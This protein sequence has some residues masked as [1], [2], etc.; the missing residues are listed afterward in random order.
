MEPAAA[1]LRR[2]SAL[3]PDE[4]EPTFLLALAAHHVGRNPERGYRRTLALAADHI[5]AEINLA[6]WLAAEGRLAASSMRLRRA[7]VLAP[8]VPQALGN[9]ALAARGIELPTRVVCGLRRVLAILPDDVPTLLNLGDALAEAGTVDGA[10][11]T[12]RKA[13]RLAADFA[14]AHYALALALQRIP[15]ELQPPDEIRASLRRACVLDPGSPAARSS[16]AAYLMAFDHTE[17]LRHL[18]RALAL[19]PHER[20]ALGTLANLVR[21]RGELGHACRLRR[22]LVALD[23]G[24]AQGLNNLALSMLDL[25]EIDF[26]TRCLRRALAIAPRRADIHN[27]LLFALTYDPALGEAELF[28]EYRR[29]EK[30]HAAPFSPLAK[31]HSNRP[32]PSRRLRVGYLSADLRDHVIAWLV[33]GLLA[34]H[35]RDQ[36]EPFCYAEVTRPDAVTERL[37][38]LVPLWHSTVGRT[39]LEIAGVI[40]ADQIDILVVLAGHTAG[41]RIGVAALA[42]APVQVNLHN[43]ST[44]GLA[45]VGYWLTDPALHPEDTAEGMT[46]RLVRIPSLYQHHLPSA[47]VVAGPLP[48]S[49]NGH[50]TFGSF[51]NPAKVNGEVI[52]L[53]AS[54]LRAV[55]GSRLALGYQGAFADPTIQAA[56]RGR[57]AAF[58]VA[59]RVR[60]LGPEP[61][62]PKHLARVAGIDIALDP[63][64]FSGGITTFEAL[65]MGVPL[66]TLAGRRFAARCGVTHLTQ[67]G[68]EELIAATPA[69]YKRIAATLAGDAVRLAAIRSSLRER[70]MSSR[71]ADPRSYAREVEAAYRTMWREWCAMR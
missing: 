37:K 28:A 39:D 30:Q 70:V 36:V 63:F 17:T 7:V 27:N 11:A 26:G 50:V 64:P 6:G 33:E 31:N 3:A 61:D 20:T 4:A 42:P 60:F 24:A 35:D 69:D 51:S 48:L 54:V 2:A 14:Q 1:H 23:P 47:D 18:R 46:E 68:L 40:R 16:L 41:N 43:L 21:L 62:R 10:V 55:P 5:G 44:S 38:R 19:D 49:A 56:F 29:W 52:A 22:R 67:V 12:L 65:W 32:D 15:Q 25:G 66:I 45:S 13:V 8:A 57:F 59:D 9:L 53:W 58:G 71:L 34:A